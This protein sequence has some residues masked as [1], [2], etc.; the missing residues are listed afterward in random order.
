MRRV[1]DSA[2]WSLGGDGKNYR[3]HPP[4]DYGCLADFCNHK[5]FLRGCRLHVVC[6]IPVFY[7]RN[8]YPDNDTNSS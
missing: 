1:L 7:L 2:A 8:L 3:E 6:W 4:R 5:E